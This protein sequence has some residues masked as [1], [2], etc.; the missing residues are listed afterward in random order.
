MDVLKWPAASPDCNPIENL[1][2]TIILKFYPKCK[3]YETVQQINAA[4]HGAWESIINGELNVLCNT[5]NR[6]C[7]AAIHYN[8]KATKY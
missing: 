4:V 8:G 6:G 7:I 5:M 2:G 1:W 3:Q